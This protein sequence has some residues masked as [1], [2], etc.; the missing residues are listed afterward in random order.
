MVLKE[1][2]FVWFSVVFLI[3]VTLSIM[4]VQSANQ[5]ANQV[6]GICTSSTC[7]R[8]MPAHDADPILRLTGTIAI[9][10][11]LYFTYVYIKEVTGK[12]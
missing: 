8:P 3:G 4:T 11:V 10:P 1:K 6:S 5:A 2:G 9:L 7:D 12:R